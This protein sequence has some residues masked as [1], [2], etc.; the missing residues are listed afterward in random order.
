MPYLEEPPEPLQFYRSWIGPNKPC[1][2][3]NALSHWP[4]LS[5]WSPDY[6]RYVSLLCRMIAVTQVLVRT[7]PVC[8][9]K[10]GS[11]VI[12]VAV[13]PNGYADAV[14]G[15]HF[16]MPEE[17][18]MTFSSVLDIIEGKV[19]NSQNKVCTAGRHMTEENGRV[20]FRSSRREQCS[21]FRSSVPTSWRSCRSSQTTWS[22][23]FPG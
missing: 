9:Q 18:Q 16:V 6:L 8:R 10:V 11:K 4:A 2:I 21:M 3:R 1:I 20:A 23:T 19:R 5:R 15:E 17:R 14:S 12:S 22:L 7:R 13:T